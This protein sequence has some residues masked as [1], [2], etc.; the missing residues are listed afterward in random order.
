MRLFTSDSSRTE[1]KVVASVVLVLIAVECGL[2]AV[3]EKISL[4]VQH[5]RAIPAITQAVMSGPEPRLLFLGNSM[6]RDGIDEEAFRGELDREGI[7]PVTTGRMFPDNTQIGEW[8]YAFKKQCIHADRIPNF[9]VISCPTDQLTDLAHFSVYKLGSTWTRYHDVFEVF[10]N[11]VTNFGDRSE[12]LIAMHSSAFANR[13]RVGSRLLDAVVPNYRMA[14]RQINEVLRKSKRQ[15]ATQARIE[16]TYHRLERLIDLA[17]SHDV[18]VAIAA[19][20]LPKYYEI[21]P[22]LTALLASHGVPLLD[23]RRVPGLNATLFKDA[24]HMKPEGAEIYSRY[25]AAKVAP[26]IKARALPSRET[27]PAR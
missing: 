15:A 22:G 6:T 20:A 17:R 16:I 11:E 10:G 4:D 3:E 27:T 21:D 25:L 1:L 5:I 14:A 8:Y 9:L 26:M 13:R 19:V 12:F 7:G 18:Q 2:R 24:L 23:C